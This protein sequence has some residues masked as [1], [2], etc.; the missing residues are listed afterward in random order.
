M[1]AAS[2]DAVTED[3][4]VERMAQL[5]VNG[6][7]RCAI[8]DAGHFDTGVRRVNDDPS[9]GGVDP[10]GNSFG[11]TNLVRNG[12]ITRLVPN[13]VAPFGLVP[14]IFR[15]TN[16]DDDNVNG[17]FKAPSLRNVELTGPYFHNGGE[18]SLRQVIDFYNRGGNFQ[19]QREFDPNVHN[20]NLGAQDKNDLVAFLLALTDQRVAFERAPF[21]HPGICVANGHPDNLQVGDPLPNTAGRKPRAHC[22]TSSAIRRVGATA[23]RTASNPSCGSINSTQ[24]PDRLAAQLKGP[25]PLA[26][27]GPFVCLAVRQRTGR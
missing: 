8:Y 10:F 14:A 2:I 6:Q 23:Y 24:P 12:S 18:L 17:T 11:E 15:T 16:C 22:S 19:D 13:A 21:D 9:L 20:L 7:P 26:G 1:T 25:V 5:P 4:R 3:A 27:T